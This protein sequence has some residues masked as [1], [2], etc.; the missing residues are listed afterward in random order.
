[1]PRYTYITKSLALNICAEMS[2]ILD[3]EFL[4]GFVAGIGIALG[5][6][7]VKDMVSW[8]LA[9]KGEP[10]F[11]V[12]MWKAVLKK[13]LRVFVLLKIMKGK[14]KEHKEVY[15]L[16]A[17]NSK[18]ISKCCFFVSINTCLLYTSDAADE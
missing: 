12:E 6:K 3:K 4:I 1:M 5:M 18:E 11:I 14:A 10:E 2:G 16:D 17:V 9:H 7:L 8:M 13:I 15:D